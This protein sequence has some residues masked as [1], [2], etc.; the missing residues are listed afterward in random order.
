MLPATSCSSQVAERIR[1]ELRAG[2]TAARVGG[3]EFVVLLDEVATSEAA[4][5]TA[6]RLNETLG[7]PYELGD[8]RH[9][10]TT[11]IGVAIGPE[12][13]VTADAMV[14]AADTAMYDAKR[15]GRGLCV[16]YRKDLHGRMP[17]TGRD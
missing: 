11:S 15:S 1:S 4:L 9:I 7:A 3:D 14:A 17:T 5:A 2:D 13:L 6:H 8:H 12:D 10:A 16:L